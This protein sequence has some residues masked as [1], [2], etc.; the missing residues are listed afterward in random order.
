MHN[1]GGKAIAAD[2]PGVYRIETGSDKLHALPHQSLGRHSGR[3]S[4][5]A[6]RFRRSGRHF[7]NELRAEAVPQDYGAAARAQRH[8]D[9]VR[10][11]IETIA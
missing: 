7:S 11:C 10:Q 8:L 6:C 1:Q 4:A 9:R 2:I 5:V 3:G